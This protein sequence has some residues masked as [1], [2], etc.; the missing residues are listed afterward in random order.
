M[1]ADVHATLEPDEAALRAAPACAIGLSLDLHWHE[2]G[3]T[4]WRSKLV[5]HGRYLC[6]MSFAPVILSTA[7]AV[8]FILT[9]WGLIGAFLAA[10]RDLVLSE[11]MF[12]RDESIQAEE[13]VE[14]EAG[15]GRGWSLDEQREIIDRYRARHDANGWP[16]PSGYSEGARSGAEAIYILRK[17]LIAARNNLI[18]AG[19]GL[20]VSSVASIVALFV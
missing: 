18:L 17:L 10:R 3:G 13:I 4:V 6:T 11:E 5:D 9:A 14:A 12:Q 8:G 7:F 16:R 20:L 15:I 2:V 19:I 1:A